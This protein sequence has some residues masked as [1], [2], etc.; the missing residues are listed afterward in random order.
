MNTNHPPATHAGWR[1]LASLPRRLLARLL[2]CGIPPRQIILMLALLPSLAAVEAL[3]AAL[4]GVTIAG[5]LPAS[6]AWHSAMSSWLAARL[7]NGAPAALA[8]GAGLLACRALASPLLAR[9]RHR[10]LRDWMLKL[11]MRAMAHELQERGAARRQRHAQTSS[12]LITQTSP[13]VIQGMLVPGLDL[14]TE[15]LLAATLLM[16][17]IAQLPV[18]GLALLAMLA[19]GLAVNRLLDRRLLRSVRGRI[20]TTEA[21]Q[22]WITDSVACAREAHLYRREPAFLAGYA[23]LAKAFGD[24]LDQYRATLDARAA[25]LELLMLGTLGVTLAWL[26]RST[27]APDVTLLTLCGVLGLRLLPAYRRING[28]LSSL[29]LT[30][31]AFEVLDARLSETVVAPPPPLRQTG[32]PLLNI[33]NLAFRYSDLEPFVLHDLDLHC[34]ASEWIAVTGASGAG[35]ST[36]VDVLLGELTPTAGEIRWG[37][38]ADALPG[39][40]YAG[41]ATAL[42]Q[43]SLRDNLSLMDPALSDALL[44]EALA[45]ACLESLIPDLPDAL[46][47]DIRTLEQRLSS[48]ER[49]RL[50]LARAVAHATDL[51]VLDEATASLDVPTEADFLARLRHA[52]PRL[53][54]LLVTHRQASLGQVDRVLHLADGRLHASPVGAGRDTLP[55]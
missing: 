42:I 14:L 8:F 21:L 43:G 36:L 18:T 5:I 40:G 50:G 26:S 2:A 4:L 30:R 3:S 9:S 17:L 44:Q 35:K 34:R 27:P 41:Q 33:R 1:W 19:A 55:N 45:I 16:V 25:L 22:R 13:Q 38:P 53:A 28:A 6:G 39:I 7:P 15:I 31:A 46:D 10:L 49:Q 52:R 48:G 24:Q 29:H 20:D 54:V 23:P 51:L 47:L 12:A 11:S 37:L 32:G